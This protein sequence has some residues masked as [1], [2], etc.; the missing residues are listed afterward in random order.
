MAVCVGY[1]HAE[2]FRD[3]H[4]SKKYNVMD[5]SMVLPES[6]QSAG[7]PFNSLFQESVPGVQEVPLILH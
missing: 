5:F 1:I 4:T 2:G 3:A 6:I 7:F